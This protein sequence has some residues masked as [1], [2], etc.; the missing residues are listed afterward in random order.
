M[1]AK[2]LRWDAEDIV[3]GTPLSGPDGLV[4]RVQDAVAEAHDAGIEA[5]HDE[6][7]DEG[8]DSTLGDVAAAL[9]KEL[10]IEVHLGIATVDSII[11][12]I[13]EKHVEQFNQGVDALAEK[14]D[15]KRAATVAETVWKIDE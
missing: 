3:A 2:L 9:S 8:V 4:G 11:E 6:S 7:Y 13:Q 12:A 14:L 5:G 1:T 10:G 15:T